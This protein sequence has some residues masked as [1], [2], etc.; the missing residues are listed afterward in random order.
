MGTRS[1]RPTRNSLSRPPTY[2]HCQLRPKENGKRK[3]RSYLLN[4]LNI[5]QFSAVIRWPMPLPSWLAPCWTEALSVTW[6]AR[7]W[8][9]FSHP[10]SA[11]CVNLIETRE[12]PR[13]KINSRLSKWCDSGIHVVIQK[14]YIIQWWKRKRMHSFKFKFPFT[15]LIE[16]L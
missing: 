9:K 1:K 2:L 8:Q 7:L 16:K 3:V 11:K 15:A 6:L 13:Y 12:D 5:P 14:K 4:R 10:Y